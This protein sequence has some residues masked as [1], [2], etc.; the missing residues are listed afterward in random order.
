MI[1]YAGPL[2][3]D[4]DTG[5]FCAIGVVP[6]QVTLEDCGTLPVLDNFCFDGSFRIDGEEQYCQNYQ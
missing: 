1:I 6:R 4:Q 2:M 3:H 5:T